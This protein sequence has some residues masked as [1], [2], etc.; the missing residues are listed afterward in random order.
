[1]PI[2]PVMTELEN[3][4]AVLEVVPD[5]VFIVAEDGIIVAVNGQ[6]EA[7]TGFGRDDLIG[8]SVDTLV[9]PRHAGSHPSHRGDYFGAARRRPMGT[10]LD[11]RVLRHDGKEIPVDI[12][13]SPLSTDRG[14][15]AVASVRDISEQ[16]RNREQVDAALAVAQAM[17]EG[18]S[19]ADVLE[20]VAEQARRLSGSAL[21]MIVEPDAEGGM[22]WTVASG[23]GADRVRGLR[24]RADEDSLNREV[25]AGGE[26]AVVADFAAD[27]R[28]H[29]KSVE[30]LQIGSALSVPLRRGAQMFGALMV[31]NPPGGRSFAR[32]DLQPLLFLA[33]QASLALEHARIQEELQRLAL[34][35]ER[36][37]IGRE[38]HDGAIQAIFAIGMSLEG[39]AARTGDPLVADR[40]RAVVA[41]LDGVIRDLR[42]YI[43]GL[44]PG[45]VAQQHLDQALR[46][47]VDD[48]AQ[49]SGVTAVSDIDPEVARALAP[50]S[51]DVV[52]LVA[53]ALSNVGRHAQALTCRVTLRREGAAALLEVE[54]DGQ[55]FDS[56]A[57]RRDG[58]GLRNLSER[59]ARLGGSAELETRPG[60][61]T[62]VRFT[63]PV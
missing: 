42:N 54:D 52:M 23:E 16:R 32:E 50:K 18:S 25:M 48:F 6:A 15:Y 58:Q 1:M 37:R 49:S 47:L 53:E 10:G 45:I 3:F 33:T 38:L 5:A 11:T 22:E 14:R 21:A 41:Q 29:P 19:A 9:P 46:Q 62:A 27:P 8:R 57:P 44:R 26:P 7:L 20:L 17:L 36:E 59:A 4:A 56:A 39:L 2:R 34:V 24:L 43:Y 55:G 12:A 28:A 63:I 51:G 40:M 60:E 31:G 30:R 61:G 13:L 35:D